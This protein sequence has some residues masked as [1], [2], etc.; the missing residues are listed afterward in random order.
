MATP[1]L[2]DFER[3]LLAAATGLGGVCRVPELVQR[4]RA[5]LAPGAEPGLLGLAVHD[6][7]RRLFVHHLLDPGRAEMERIEVPVTQGDARR[8]EGGERRCLVLQPAAEPGA[9]NA[10]LAERGIGSIALAPLYFDRRFLGTVFVAR[11]DAQAPA[12]EE[13]AYLVALARIVEPHLLNCFTDE[14][15]ARGDRRRDAL[16][17]LSRVINT[18]LDRKVVLHLARAAIGAIEGHRASW[19]GLLEETRTHWRRY[20]RPAE[21]LDDAREPD[22]FPVEGSVLARLLGSERTYE[23]DDLAR[24]AEFREDEE[25]LALGVRRYVVTPLRAGGKVLGAFL[26][27]TDD[28]H[29]SLRV[30]VWLIENVALQIALAIDNAVHYEEVQRLSARRE[31]ENVYLREEIKNEHDAQGMI[32]RSPAM[33]HVFERIARVAG[34]DSTVL[35]SGPTGVGKELVARAIHESSAR[36]DQPLVKLNCAAIPEGMVESELFGHERGAFTSAV[37]RR[38]GRFELAHNGTLFLDEIGELSLAVQAKCL[39]V[40]QSGEFERVG[41]TKTL[42]S[43]ARI[44]AATNRDLGKALASGAFRSDLYYRLNVFPIEVP[45]LDERRE[46][47]PQ[48]AQAFLEQFAR[49]MGK[50][51]V[52]IAPE[53]LERLC[54][55]SWPG[56]VRELKH[57]IERAVILCDGP[58]LSIDDEPSPAGAPEPAA[59]P[60]ASALATLEQVEE[61]HIRSAL[62]CTGGVIEGP[63]GAAALLGLKG[64][65]LRFRMKRMGIRRP[66]ESQSAA[67]FR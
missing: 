64:S 57:V 2:D 65:T 62:L 32:G 19:I 53:A 22:L 35:V 20:D 13:Q 26:F 44:V 7:E 40:L 43:N 55:R 30:D 1:V 29:P 3:R 61:A 63:H 42:T 9:F 66:G 47:V 5:A 31:R 48:L 15:F 46:D 38:I 4:L 11:H 18:S 17:E 41:G 28:P 45:A 67:G 54:A 33:R 52:S 12:R 59:R 56:N 6:E 34:T 36:K 60:H 14:R 21:Y 50:R 27:G 8:F 39:R 51:L 24:R 49:R 10:A 58:L 25:L 37:D 23:S 16:R